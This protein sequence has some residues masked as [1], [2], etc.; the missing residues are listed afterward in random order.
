[1]SR[2]QAVHNPLRAGFSGVSLR[3][4]SAA[5]PQPYTRL[6]LLQLPVRHWQNNCWKQQ[7]SIPVAGR[8]RQRYSDVK[9]PVLRNGQLQIA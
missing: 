5:V 1:M 9:G 4:I 7:F 3:H 2:E 6:S 8:L